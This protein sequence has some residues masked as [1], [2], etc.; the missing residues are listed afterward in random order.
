MIQ[1]YFIEVCYK[2]TR[3]SGFQVQNNVDTIQLQVETALHTFYRTPFELTG[4]SRTDAG[5]HALQNYFHFDTDVLIDAAHIYN[6]NAILPNDIVIRSLKKVQYDAHC[7][8]HARSRSYRYYI[9]DQKDPFTIESAWYYPYK[10]NVE[11]L[12]TACGLIL[13]THDFTSFSKRNTQ[14]NTYNCNIINA[15]WSRTGKGIHLDI[16]ADRFLRGMVRALVATMLKVGRGTMDIN[17]FAA[18][19][20]AKN[21]AAADFSAPAHGLFLMEVEMPP[22]LF[23]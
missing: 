12:N 21:C 22:E 13:G 2:G 11:T 17:A 23:F 5:V 9:T 16:K 10:I 6:L 20:S 8:F 18:I 7:R 14:V 19:L 1:R 15:Q 4:S 3:Y